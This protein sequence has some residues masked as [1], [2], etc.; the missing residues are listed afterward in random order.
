LLSAVSSGD[1]T[2]L[3]G[4]EVFEAGPSPKERLGAALRRLRRL[5]GAPFRWRRIARR[6]SPAALARVPAQP[7]AF[8]VRIVRRALVPLAILGGI[9][10]LAWAINRLLD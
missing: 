10:L 1:P 9:L 3:P 4:G 2:A 5:L 7:W 8:L 6:R